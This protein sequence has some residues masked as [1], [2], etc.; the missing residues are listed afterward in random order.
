MCF[1]CQRGEG[2]RCAPTLHALE[3]CTQFR[4]F[5]GSW[6]FGWDWGC[7]SFV[8]P[9]LLLM[10]VDQRIHACP[11]KRH[12]SRLCAQAP[13]AVGSSCMRFNGSLVSSR[14]SVMRLGLKKY[15]PQL[16]LRLDFVSSF[17]SPGYLVLF[18]H[19]SC[20]PLAPL[21]AES[22]GVGLSLQ[23]SLGV[24]SKRVG[25]TVFLRVGLRARSDVESGGGGR[26][27][28]TC[29]C[30]GA[31][32]PVRDVNPMA[33]AGVATPCLISKLASQ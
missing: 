14:F 18:L 33:L 19:F 22:V 15:E 17:A 21:V 13:C 12:S 2:G 7:A 28:A 20:A 4:W 30:L 31:N 8:I 5:V 27:A 16:G 25:L 9:A 26:A 23:R 3:F 1:S 6:A 32:R 11:L 24:Y 29:G 10:T